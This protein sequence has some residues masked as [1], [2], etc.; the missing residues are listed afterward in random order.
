MKGRA[1]DL[2]SMW[3]LGGYWVRV[4]MLAELENEM[5]SGISLLSQFINA[6]QTFNGAF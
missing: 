1:E 6:K 4:T 5:L 2:E 3:S